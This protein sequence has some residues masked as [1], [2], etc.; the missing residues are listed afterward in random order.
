MSD[1]RARIEA[2]IGVTLRESGRLDRAD[3][4]ARCPP[5]VPPG[6]R[7]DDLAVYW[8]ENGFVNVR[9]RDGLLLAQPAGDSAGDWPRATLLIDLARRLGAVPGPRI[10]PGCRPLWL[11]LE[12][13]LHWRQGPRA[14]RARRN[15]RLGLDRLYESQPLAGY[16]EK[17]AG[18]PT[19]AQM[20]VLASAV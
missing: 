1:L 20:A 12:S 7:P 6:P 19:L 9:I 5:S 3:L 2:Q 11:A 8:F 13:M 16:R 17:A 14:E 18:F 4:C 15:L 10:A